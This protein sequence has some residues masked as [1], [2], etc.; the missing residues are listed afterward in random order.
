MWIRV[1]KLES[2]PCKGLKF[3][4]GEQKS[5]PAMAGMAV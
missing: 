4:F 5:G 1:S 2:E 3:K